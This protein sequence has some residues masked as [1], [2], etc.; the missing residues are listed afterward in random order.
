MDWQIKLYDFGHYRLNRKVAHEDKDQP[1]T[2][3]VFFRRSE[4][5][6][7]IELLKKTYERRHYE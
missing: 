4:I 2:N 3:S 6:E 7:I 1:L 5:P